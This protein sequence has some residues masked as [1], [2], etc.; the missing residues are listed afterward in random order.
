M[1]SYW[2]HEGNALEFSLSRQRQKVVMNKL[3]E[4]SF[5]RG[6]WQP[7][8]ICV[9]PATHSFGKVGRVT[10]VRVLYLV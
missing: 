5:Q 9:D 2:N 10:P 7:L 1:W 8:C 6:F 4:I 3:E